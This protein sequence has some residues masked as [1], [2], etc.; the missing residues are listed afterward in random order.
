MVEICKILVH[1]TN[2]LIKGISWLSVQARFDR[3]FWL[4]S[5]LRLM[6]EEKTP[7]FLH[8]VA[9]LATMLAHG[10]VNSPA[11]VF[12]FKLIFK[13]S[14]WI[15]PFPG[16]WMFVLVHPV[17]TTETSSCGWNSLS[18]SAPAYNIS[19]LVVFGNRIWLNFN[20]S[21][22][23]TNLNSST[24]TVVYVRK[25]VVVLRERDIWCWSSQQTQCPSWR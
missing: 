7:I 16:G 8:R 20:F 9:S 24:R 5:L 25:L 3:T 10:P 14:S 12:I 13:F 4:N 15:F 1:Y 17:A 22:N 19:D 2:E 23:L 6:R 11:Q 18:R 21:H